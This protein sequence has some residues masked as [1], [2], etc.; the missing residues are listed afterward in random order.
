MKRT[1]ITLTI[2][3]SLFALTA[4]TDS[5]WGS[6]GALGNECRVEFYQDGKV[7]RTW[8][9][10]GKVTTGD[11]GTRY[12]FVDKATGAYVRIGVQNTVVTTIED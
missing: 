4:C 10:T 2:I 12:A 1:L 8:T 6:V 11:N 3:A 5:W 7:V 9:S